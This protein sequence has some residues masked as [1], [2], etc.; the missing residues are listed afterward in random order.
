MPEAES[1][2]V[3]AHLSDPHI[4]PLPAPSFGQL[5]SKRI[6][7]FL[8]WQLRRRKLHKR[9]TLDGLVADLK[10]QAPSHVAITGDVTNISLPAEFEQA[11]EWFRAIGPAEWVS[12]IPGNHDAYVSQPWEDSWQL[13]ADYMSADDA[14]PEGFEDFPYVRE[15][16]GVALIGLSS[17]VPTLPA[18]ASGHLG[19]PQL[20]KLETCLAELG[21]RGR[22]RCVL[23]HHPPV[24]GI[25]SPRKALTDAAAFREVLG[26]HGAE[27]VLH[28]HDHSFTV[29]EIEGPGGPIP[30]CGVPSASSGPGGHKPLAQ[31]HLYRIS[32]KTGA[33]RTR[34]HVR[35]WEGP[36]K[37]YAESPAVDL[38]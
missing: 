35:R 36:G 25:V 5:A 6:M 11:A 22:F 21:A 32:G 30:V 31:Y 14:H 17:A 8:S 7:G 1:E 9:E 18:Y 4:A 15:R 12:V 2:F 24:P 10:G 19:E 23:V 20:A 3:L 38:I 13:W 16:G 33:W 34:M 27:L 37:G 28:G 26:R 29:K